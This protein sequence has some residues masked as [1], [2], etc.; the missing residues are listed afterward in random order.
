M[1]KQRELI[2]IKPAFVFLIIAFVAIG[3]I[4]LVKFENKRA[5]KYVGVDHKMKID[6]ITITGDEK[7]G[8]LN[9]YFVNTS[10]ILIE[11]PTHFDDWVGGA[12]IIS[13]TSKPY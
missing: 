3:F 4:A 12:P 1:K 5:A 11:N 2:R 9:G 10:A 6:S 8:V 7:Y 13:F